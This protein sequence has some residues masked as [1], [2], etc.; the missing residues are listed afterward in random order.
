MAKKKH[1]EFQE[2]NNQFRESDGL[3]TKK[4]KTEGRWK[5]NPNQSF[6]SEEEEDDFVDDGH[7]Y[8]NTL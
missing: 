4:L 5:F 8:E 3:K 6:S 1:Y 7:Q 2:S